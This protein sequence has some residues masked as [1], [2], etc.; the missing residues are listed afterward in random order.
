LPRPARLGQPAQVRDAAWAALAGERQAG[1][2]ARLQ[3]APRYLRERWGSD[4]RRLKGVSRVFIRHQTRLKTGRRHHR[5]ANLAAQAAFKQARRPTARPATRATRV[6][7]G[8]G[9]LWAQG[10]VSAALVPPR[11]TTALG[12]RRPGCMALAVCGRGADDGA[13]LLSL[14]PQA[15]WGVL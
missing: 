4:D 12:I 1:R 9:P 15:R 7:A 2:V 11:D 14:A 8:R 10:L 5:R 13:P 3:D 6:G